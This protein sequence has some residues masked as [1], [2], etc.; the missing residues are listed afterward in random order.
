MDAKA[1][2]VSDIDAVRDDVAALK[3]DVADLV[4]HLKNGTNGVAH[5]AANRL[6]EKAGE[7]YD[8]LEDRSRR[9]TAAAR[10]QVEEHPLTAIAIAFA[11][12]FIGGRLLLR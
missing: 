9:T 4:K 2:T 10:H 7:V 3:Q 1:K 6:R 11:V 12:G 5:D 8:D